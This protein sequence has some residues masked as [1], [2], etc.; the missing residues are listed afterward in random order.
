MVYI[1][2]F[3]VFVVINRGR[4]FEDYD[5]FNHWALIIKNMYLYNEYGTAKGSIVTFNEY[6]P[7]TTCFQ[8]IMLSIKGMYLE[9]LI[10]MAQ[11]ILYLSIIIPVCAKV[12]FKKNL[13][14]LL[15]I[16]P[17]ILVLPI[18]L[19]EDFFVNILVDGFLGVLFAMG[20]FH[21]YQNDKNKL[22][23]T[24][25]ITLMITAI[26]LTKTTGVALG[27]LLLVFAIL[28]MKKDKLKVVMV[29]AILPI[30]LVSSWYIKINLKNVKR[31]WDLAK[32][33]QQKEE[34]SIRT[35]G[36]IKN[37]F[38]AMLEH[39][40]VIGKK[41]CMAYKILL[42]IAYS[43]YVYRNIS[44][45][46]QKRAYIYIIIEFLISFVIF[47]VGLIAT[48]LKLFTEQE[49][50]Y[51]ASYDRY[52][53]TM[54]LGWLIL[55]TAILLKENKK[56]KLSS[57]YIFVVVGLILLPEGVIYEKYINAKK[58]ISSSHIKRDYYYREF[59]Q[60]EEVITQ[61]DK[62]FFISDTQM[63]D[64]M[65]MMLHKYQMMT[66]N[67]ANT[68]AKFNGTVKELENILLEDYDYVYIFKTKDSFK[69]KYKV[70]FAE[71]QVK[72]GTLYKVLI[73][74]EKVMLQPVR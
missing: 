16:I 8:Y 40:E 27:I 67:I 64:Q 70:L 48:Y 56:I 43:I 17:A 73:E 13:K 54:L 59:N 31:E 15:L 50:A 57:I 42:L 68:Q 69:E 29:L 52:M 3:F 60:Y 63:H 72:D 21:I 58:Y 28:K 41:M 10:I 9:D 20:L 33:F 34:S 47:I 1:L 39:N 6:P 61:K 32:I 62:I 7:F 24:I 26:A 11:N 30:V 25:I 65:I 55:N 18:I 14:N 35:E 19:Y 46:S 53:H 74:K 45:K 23:K 71:E 5:E 22:Y 44:R 36:V 4:I 12:S 38:S 51:L 37:F 49:T 66:N 2:L